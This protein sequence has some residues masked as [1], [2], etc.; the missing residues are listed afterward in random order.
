VVAA[1]LGVNENR[2]PGKRVFFGDNTKLPEDIQ[3]A[4]YKF[5]LDNAVIQ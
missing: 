1:Y 3:V 5:M 2:N 4:A